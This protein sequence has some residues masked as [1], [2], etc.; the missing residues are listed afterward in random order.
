MDDEKVL[1]FDK[2]LESFFNDRAKNSNSKET[3]SNQKDL[4]MRVDEMRNPN[5]ATP[6]KKKWGRIS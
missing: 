3:K 2:I 4:K 5:L 1:K 6:T